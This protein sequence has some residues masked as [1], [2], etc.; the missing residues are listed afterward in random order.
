MSYSRGVLSIDALSEN[1][2][3]V[4]DFA[5]FSVPVHLIVSVWEVHFSCYYVE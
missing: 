2:D 5:V 3:I 1:I 4:R